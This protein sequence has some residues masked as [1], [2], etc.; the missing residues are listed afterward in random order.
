MRQIN[1][2]II[3]RRLAS[4]TWGTVHKQF[5]CGDGI[6]W[7]IAERHIGYV[8][9]TAINKEL[10]K[11]TKIVATRKNS[12]HFEPSEQHFASFDEYMDYAIVEWMYPYILLKTG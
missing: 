9:D 8:V 2:E 3:A 4:Q 10:V 6:W 1:N 5:T 7:F 11:Y 12:S